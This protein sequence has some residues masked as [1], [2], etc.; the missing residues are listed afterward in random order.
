[1]DTVLTLSLT[2][3]TECVRYINDVSIGVGFN[4]LNQFYEGMTKIQRLNTHII[5]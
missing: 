5:A 3:N 2:W 1:M 4:V